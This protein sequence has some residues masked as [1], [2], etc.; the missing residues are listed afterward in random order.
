MLLLSMVMLL[1][2]RTKGKNFYKKGWRSYL[3]KEG[4]DTSDEPFRILTNLFTN[5]SGSIC[6]R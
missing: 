2:I 1:S 6:Q 4:A 3:I 5:K